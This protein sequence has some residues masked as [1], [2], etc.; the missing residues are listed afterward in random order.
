[1][2]QK[3]KTG[4]QRPRK[5]TQILHHIGKFGKMRHIVK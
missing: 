3:E 1:M 2:T 4:K 5:E